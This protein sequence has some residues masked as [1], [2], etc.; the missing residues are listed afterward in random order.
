[1]SRRAYGRRYVRAMPGWQ[2]LCGGRF[3]DDVAVEHH[4]SRVRLVFTSDDVQQCRLTGAVGGYKTHGLA[5]LYV[6]PISLR[7][8]KSKSL[9]TPL[10]EESVHA[11]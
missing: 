11:M 8:T 4:R 10:M 7:A 1:M 2:V 9:V 6:K 5:F 3:A